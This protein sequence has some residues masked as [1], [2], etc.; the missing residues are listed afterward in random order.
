MHKTESAVRRDPV[1]ESSIIYG[2]YLK[3]N[4]SPLQVLLVKSPSSKMGFHL[5]GVNVTILRKKPCKQS[6]RQKY[7]LRKH[8]YAQSGFNLKAQKPSDSLTCMVCTNAE[9]IYKI[10]VLEESNKPV[11]NHWKRDKNYISAFFDLRKMIKD[12]EAEE[13]DP[14]TEL[15]LK[16]FYHDRKLRQTKSHRLVIAKPIAVA[17]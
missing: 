12:E 7:E 10:Y 6:K 9:Q 15:I 13:I 17:S 2:V 14:T 8:V 11:S 3:P 16:K 4:L 5:P 1:S